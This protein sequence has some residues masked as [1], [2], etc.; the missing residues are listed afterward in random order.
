MIASWWFGA[1][2]GAGLGLAY[3]GASLWINRWAMRFSNPRIFVY[4]SIGGI[5]VRMAVALSL[6]ALIMLLTPIHLIAFIGTFFIVFVLGLALEIAILHRS[7]R[8]DR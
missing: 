8:A 2:I 3:G 4:L 1:A 6:V 5:V 7:A